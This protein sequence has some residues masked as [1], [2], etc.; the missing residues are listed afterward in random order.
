MDD[1]VALDA[2]QRVGDRECGDDAASPPASGVSTRPTTSSLTS[3]R[4]ASWTSTATASDGTS[5]S[6]TR[7][8]SAR[9]A[10]R[11]DCAH[12]AGADLLREQDRRLLPAG[13]AATTIA[14][15]QSDS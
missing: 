8:D 7:T 4:A 3:G 13:R 9:G 15:I 1:A 5:A 12:L 14:S 11:D 10:A 2:L 6:A